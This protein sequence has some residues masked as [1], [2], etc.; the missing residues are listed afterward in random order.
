[1]NESRPVWSQRRSGFASIES[2]T[3]EV[4]ECIP[5][6]I[7]PCDYAIG[8]GRCELDDNGCCVLTENAEILYRLGRHPGYE[9]EN[10]RYAEKR[11][12]RNEKA[13]RD[14]N[15]LSHPATLE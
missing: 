4:I 8:K 3:A 6:A 15:K 7:G 2:R 9:Q 11:S 12:H 10:E 13:E 14:S 1:M 5:P